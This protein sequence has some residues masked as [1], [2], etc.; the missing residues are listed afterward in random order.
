MQADLETRNHFGQELAK[1]LPVAGVAENGTAFVA[2]GGEMIPT[3]GPF[4]AKGSGHERDSNAPV[5]SVNC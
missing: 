5:G 4:D 2:S 3:A 1:M